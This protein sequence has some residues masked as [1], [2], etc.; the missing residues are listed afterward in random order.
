MLS[1]LRHKG[2]SRKILW[3]V[4]VIVILSFGVFGTAYRLE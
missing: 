1:S 3:A 2:V 4:A